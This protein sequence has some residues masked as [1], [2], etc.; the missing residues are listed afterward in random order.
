[1][2]TGAYLAQSHD[3][4]FFTLKVTSQFLTPD[5]GGYGTLRVALHELNITM[6]Q[7][8]EFL[9]GRQNSKG[10]DRLLLMLSCV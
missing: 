8:V 3:D 4:E 9:A 10:K 6:E 7:E 1:L 2:C 5:S